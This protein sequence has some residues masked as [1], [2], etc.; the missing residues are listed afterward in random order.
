[1]PSSEYTVWKKRLRDQPLPAAVVDLDAVDANVSLFRDAISGRPVTIRVACKSIRHPWLLR[2]ILDKGGDQ[3]VGLMTYSAREAEFLAAQGFDDFLMGYPISRRADAEALAGLAAKGVRAIATIDTEAHLP[4]LAEAATAAN[5]TVPVCVDIDMSW[6]PARGRLHFGVRRSAVR[7]AEQA[8]ALAARIADT[9]NLELSALLAYEA[10]VAGIRERNPTSRH[11]DPIRRLIKSRSLPTILDLRKRVVDMLRADGHDVTIV[12][13]GGTGS[14]FWTRD[15]P[16]VTEVTVGSGFVCS[17]LFDGYRGLDLRPA[18]FF[19]LAVVRSADLGFVT[20]GGGGYL[21]SG[22]AAPDRAPIVHR[23]EGLEPL[24]MEGFGEV[25]TP[26]KLS[27]TAPELHIG[28][29][30]I[31]RH[32]K[33]GELAE[34]FN[35]YLFVRG[36]RVI[37]REPTYRGLGQAF[38]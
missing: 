23:P 5:A 11:L 17:H 6:R 1:M 18:V 29:P 24:G 31:C 30:V 7:S 16:S 9:S 34:R 36:D 25:Q 19:A 12:N 27:K 38:M 33:A 13:G 35:E 14:I 22:P 20:C 3:F 28:D 26:F 2:Y 21:A 37:A 15:D 4:V 8:S 32:A 10:Q